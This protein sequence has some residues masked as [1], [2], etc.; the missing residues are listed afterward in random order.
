MTLLIFELGLKARRGSLKGF[1]GRTLNGFCEEVREHFTPILAIEYR[2]VP[3]RRDSEQI[4]VT[5][6][7]ARSQRTTLAFERPL[8]TNR[9]SF[10][11]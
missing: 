9:W 1:G 11:E 5:A 2:G 6:N 10:Q 8:C 7:E 3:S 4:M